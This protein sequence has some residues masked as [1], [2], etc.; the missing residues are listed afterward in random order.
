MAARVYVL[1]SAEAPALKKMLEYD[2]Y[3]DQ[4]AIPSMPKEWSDA[5]Y[6]SEHPEL[7]QQIEEKEKEISGA[8]D[9][10][11]NDKEANIIFARQDYQL[12]DGIGIGLER[13]KSYLY[14]S[15]DDSFLDGADAK[16]KKNFKSIERADAETEQKVIGIIEDER[17]RTDAGIGLIFG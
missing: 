14:I 1:D 12:R 6:R 8:L 11:K 5:K 2:P 4:G 9:R 3:L 15:A 7:A 13:G 10:L 17:N 16:M